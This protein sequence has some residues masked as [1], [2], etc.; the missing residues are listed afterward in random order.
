MASPTMVPS[1]RRTKFTMTAFG[2]YMV[3]V[4]G[5]GMGFFP[6]Q[7]LS[8]SGF[9]QADDTF[10]RMMGLVGGAL[11]LYYLFMVREN[12][13]A[14]LKFSVFVRYLA[15]LVIAALVFLADCDRNLLTIALGDTLGATLTLIAIRMDESEHRASKRDR[16]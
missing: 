11:G 1:Y 8:F 2:T 12:F 16:F 15:G 6:K 4:A 5:I 3:L 13:I 10:F 9:E 7:M 14:G